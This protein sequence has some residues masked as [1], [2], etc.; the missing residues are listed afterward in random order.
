MPQSWIKD[1]PNHKGVFLSNQNNDKESTGSLK[2]SFM[3]DT[4]ISRVDFRN[5]YCPYRFLT[6]ANGDCQ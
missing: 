3:L 5:E 6:H 4:L 1:Q 2:D